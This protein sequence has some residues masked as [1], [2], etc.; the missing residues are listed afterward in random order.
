MIAGVHV[1]L[2]VLVL[3]PVTGCGGGESTTVTQSPEAKKA[4][5]GGQ[6]AMEEFMRGKGKGAPKK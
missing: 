3:L 6:K 4:D 1:V 2:L 5:E